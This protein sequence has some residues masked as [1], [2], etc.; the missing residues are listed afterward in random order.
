M[1]EHEDLL[2]SLLVERYRRFAPPDVRDATTDQQVARAL[3]G[4]RAQTA[5]SSIARARRR[6]PEKINSPRSPS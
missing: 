1:S 6:N 4:E 2:R 3:A 5:A